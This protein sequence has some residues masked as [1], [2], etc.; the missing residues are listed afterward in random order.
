[1]YPI[2]N[3]LK[4]IHTRVPFMYLQTNNTARFLRSSWRSFLIFLAQNIRQFFWIMATDILINLFLE[5]TIL[6]TFLKRCTRIY[7][8]IFIVDL[9]LFLVVFLFSKSVC[10][11][12]LLTELK[13]ILMGFEEFFFTGIFT[14]FI[15]ESTSYYFSEISV[16]S[17]EKLTVFKLFMMEILFRISSLT[18]LDLLISK[19]S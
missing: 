3:F 12:E 9:R 5:I 6:I 1:M 17:A 10:N 15:G 8:C 2:F 19:L 16:F 13:L 11:F 14:T 7:L 4:F 18:R